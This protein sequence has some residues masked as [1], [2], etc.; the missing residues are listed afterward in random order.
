M[1]AE[2]ITVGDELLIGQVV[3]TNSA[4]IGSALNDVGIEVIRITSVR[5]RYHEIFEA[6]DFALNKVDL[7]I[8]TGGLGPTKDDITK[9]VLCDY[10]KT[11]LVFNQEVFE[12][13]KRL[14]A[15]RIPLNALNRDQAMVP[16]NCLT[17]NNRVGTASVSWVEKDGKTLISLPGVPHEMKTVMMEEILPKLREQ[18]LGSIIHQTFLVRN[19]PESV[20]AERLEFWEASLP[21]CVTLAY[22]PDRKSVV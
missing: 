10:F 20:L 12:N 14:L 4:W 1:F 18:S 6:I 22:L 8:M 5:D 11:K 21:K 17:I 9:Q 16:E 15:H 2:I 7:V 19:N 3:D 13:V